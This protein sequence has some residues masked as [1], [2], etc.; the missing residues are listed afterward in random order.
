VRQG[1]W[2][3]AQLESARSPPGSLAQPSLTAAGRGRQG[4]NNSSAKHK[5]HLYGLMETGS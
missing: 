5:R 3:A 1:R 2:V 4:H